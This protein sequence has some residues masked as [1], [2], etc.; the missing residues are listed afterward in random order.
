MTHHSISQTFALVSPD[1]LVN[2]FYRSDMHKVDPSVWILSVARNHQILSVTRVF[3]EELCLGVDG[4]LHLCIYEPLKV[5]STKFFVVR[6]FKYL[7]EFEPW[8]Y[9][10]INK[11]TVATRALGMQMIDYM[12][13]NTNEKAPHKYR[14]AHQ[15]VMTDPKVREALVLV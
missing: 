15:S 8:D 10:V 9:E 4:N 6:S 11:L 14:S 7:N 13:I 1:A 3:D 12:L 2:Y 5:H